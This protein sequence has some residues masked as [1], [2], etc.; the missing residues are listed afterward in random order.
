MNAIRIVHALDLSCSNQLTISNQNAHAFRPN[1]IV[2]KMKVSR[3]QVG[4]MTKMM[5]AS[6]HYYVHHRCS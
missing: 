2:V 4:A 6:W 3:S 5:F 1:S